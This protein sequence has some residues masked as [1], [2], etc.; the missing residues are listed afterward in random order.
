MPGSLWLD[1]KNGE[2]HRADFIEVSCSNTVLEQVKAEADK[3][4]PT[5]V[6]LREIAAGKVGAE[7]L[8]RGQA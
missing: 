6:A 5:V 7:V 1:L 2:L 8:N 4:K 3:D